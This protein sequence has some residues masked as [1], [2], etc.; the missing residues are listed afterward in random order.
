MDK[1]FW[2]A[3]AGFVVF[4]GGGSLYLWRARYQRIK[5]LR[6][7]MA[8]P[9]RERK[10]WY[11]LRSR[12]YEI[13]AYRPVERVR[14]MTPEEPLDVSLQVEWLVRWQKEIWAVIRRP[15]SWGKKECLQ[16]FFPALVMYEVK[17]VLWYDEENGM[18]LPWYVEGERE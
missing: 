8:L 17:G 1:R 2:M 12:G 13:V 4:V 18:L 6:M 11:R 15:L 14:I 5:M 9:K 10:L 16:S 7:L 3:F